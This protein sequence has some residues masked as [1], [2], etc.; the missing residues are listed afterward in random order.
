MSLLGLTLRFDLLRVTIGGLAISLGS[1]LYVF[2]PGLKIAAFITFSVG[3][4]LAADGLITISSRRAV[5]HPRWSQDRI[6]KAL[7]TAPETAT[8]QILQ[9][10]FPEE[11]FIASL[12]RLYLYHGRRFH[13]RVMLMNCEQEGVNDVLA[14]RVKLRWIERSKAV[15]DIIQTRDGLLRL[16]RNVDNRLRQIALADG[17]F[18]TIDVQIRFY[19][20]MP[21]GPIYRI[22]EEVMFVGFYLN[23]TSSVFGPMIEVRKSKSPQLWQVLEWNLDSGWEASVPYHPPTDSEE[24]SRG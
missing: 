13:L 11:D 14:A 23:H 20:F 19:D 12:E 18:E 6:L 2:D 21:F 7:A 10:W 5:V 22:G 17:R 8:V 15:V 3:V 4:I 1:G 24:L 16:K 9:T